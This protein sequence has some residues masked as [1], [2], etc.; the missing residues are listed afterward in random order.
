MLGLFTACLRNS[1]RK[2]I[3]VQNVTVVQAEPNKSPN[4]TNHVYT[5]TFKDDNTQT[6]DESESSSE[7]DHEPKRAS[8]PLHHPIEYPEARSLCESYQPHP[9]VLIDYNAEC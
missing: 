8:H 2:N 6:E 1:K 4:P 7:E 5:L 3:Q 9:V